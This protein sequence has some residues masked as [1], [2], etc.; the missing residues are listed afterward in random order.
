[1]I[2]YWIHKFVKNEDVSLIE[3][4]LFEETESILLPELS[5]CFW[6]PILTSKLKN[7]SIDITNDTYLQYI[8]GNNVSNQKYKQINFDEVTLQLLD[9]VSHINIGFRPERNK[10]LALCVTPNNCSFISVKNNYNGL[11]ENDLIKC[12]G[13]SI[14]KKVSKDISYIFI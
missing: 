14:D 5:V 8:I 12:F 4:K 11:A 1:M 13:F 2:T 6:N 9:F 3:Y 7:L 10:S